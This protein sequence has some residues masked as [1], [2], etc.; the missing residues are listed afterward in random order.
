MIA[1][2]RMYSWSPSLAAAWRRLLEW[3]AAAANVDMPVIEHA[4]PATLD[5]LWAR[6]D[7]GCVFMC[8]FPWA[9]RPERAHLLAAPVPSP[10]RYGGR[11]VYFT[12]FIVRAD[13][14]YRTLEDTFGARIAYSTEESH[15]GYNA[16]R[17]HLLRYVTPARPALYSKVLGPY[18]SQRPVLKAVIDGEA[19][20]AAFDSYALD[21]MRKHSPDVMARVRVVATTVG[22]P[23]PPLV[24]SSGVDP[25]TC[26]RVR[27]SL[28]R[29]DRAPELSET[30]EAL[31]LERFVPIQPGAFQVFL[32]RM[33]AAEAVG[34][35]KLA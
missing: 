21:L 15:S 29:V 24:A 33:K 19:D 9:L 1:C 3:V 23:S 22:A 2:A 6:E 30:L 8:G 17:Y 32:D 4:A 16:A 31:L 14:P 34:Y 11:P 13:S 26:A 10:T 35:P 20:V 12:E 7:M 27:E 25:E 5:S 28:V 18:V